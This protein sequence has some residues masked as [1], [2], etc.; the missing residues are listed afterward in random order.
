MDEQKINERR[1]Q[2]PANKVRRWM[3]GGRNRIGLDPDIFMVILVFGMILLGTLV[4]LSLYQLRTTLAQQDALANAQ[5]EIRA[6][7]ASINRQNK[8]L[9][10]LEKR[11]RINSYQTAYRFCTRNSVDRAAMHWLLADQ[12]PRLARTTPGRERLAPIAL[13]YLRKLEDVHGLPILDCEPNV[14]GE[15]AKYL[16]PAKQRKFVK[17]WRDNKL[18]PAQIGICQIRI[19]TLS[20]PRACL[21]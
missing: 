17:L 12:L 4:G 2:T 15:S 11:D 21:K 9:V 14:R 13:R 20:D 18:T 1:R 16:P 8:M 10:R 3:S 5:N 7:Q 19:G 6:N